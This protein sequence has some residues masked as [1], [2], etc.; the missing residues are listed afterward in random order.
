MFFVLFSIYGCGSTSV[1]LDRQRIADRPI[2]QIDLL[3][4][5]ETLEYEKSVAGFETGVNAFAVLGAIVGSAV[6][7]AINASRRKSFETIKESAAFTD[8]NSYFKDQLKL[9]TRSSAFADSVSV[10][11]VDDNV[12]RLDIPLL[13]LRYYISENFRFVVVAT[14]VSYRQSEATGHA[15]TRTYSS[16]QT[17]DDISALSDEKSANVEFWANNINLLASLVEAGMSD[18]I[19]KFVRD[20][21]G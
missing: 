5:Q 15:Y 4:Y 14:D 13:V 1:E 8:F 19:Q 20:F 18:V 11:P 7:A 2:S 21:S 9:E 17:I 10:Q 12:V 3:T 16:I 6:D